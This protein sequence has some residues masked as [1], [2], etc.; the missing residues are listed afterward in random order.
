LNETFSDKILSHRKFLPKHSYKW[1]EIEDNE[2]YLDFSL[3]RHSLM[4]QIGS[5]GMEIDAPGDSRR[6]VGDIVQVDIVSQEDTA[7][8]NEW[9][10]TYLSGR[11]MITRIAHN[12]GRNEYNMILTLTKDSFDDPIPDYKEANLN[13]V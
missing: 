8:K 12:I 5:V 10:D 13:P 9:R 2:Q 7:K 3:N 11:Y 1:D 4:N 6:R